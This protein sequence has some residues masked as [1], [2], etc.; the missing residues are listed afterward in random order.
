MADVGASAKGEG[1]DAPPAD[2]RICFHG[3]ERSAARWQRVH[4]GRPS[5][6]RRRQRQQHRKED[7]H[8]RAIREIG[9]GEL[10]SGRPTPQSQYKYEAAI[11]CNPTRAK[12]T[13]NTCTVNPRTHPPAR[14]I[15]PVSISTRG[16]IASR[17]M[18]YPTPHGHV[19]TFKSAVGPRPLASAT[20]G[21]AWPG[22][23]RGTSY[24][25]LV[26]DQ[27]DPRY[28]LAGVACLVVQ[29]MLYERSAT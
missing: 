22:G 20:V 28:D 5:W 16:V 3:R 25:G 14:K 26:C 21:R 19:V 10:V 29:L 8:E 13:P 9:S 27:H 6:H 15:Y 17:K 7:P 18:L 23:T 12:H 1:G 11:C 4:Q 2:V 24:D